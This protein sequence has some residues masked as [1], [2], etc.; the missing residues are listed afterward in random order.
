MFKKMAAAMIAAALYIFLLTQCITAQTTEFTYQ[1]TLQ[2]SS[3]PATGSFD[4]EFQLW[5]SLIGGTQLGATLTR[6]AVAVSAGAFSVKLDFGANFPGANR[7]LE[8]H[9]RSAGVGSFIPLLPRQAVSSSPYSVQ[10]LIAANATNATQLG[11]IA[12]NQYMTTTGG[13]TSYIQNTTTPQ[14]ANYNISGNGTVGGILSATSMNVTTGL[15][16]DSVNVNTIYMI[17]GVPAFFMSNGNTVAGN[18]AGLFSTG[19]SNSFYGQNAG[20]QNSIGGSNSFFGGGA[21]YLSGAGNENSYFGLQA[22]NNSQGN[23]NSFFGVN[24]G[25]ANLNGSGNTLI[26]HTAFTNGIVNNATA[27]GAN[28]FVSQSNSMVLGSI[29]GVNGATA[30]TNVGIGT[31][32]PASK[33]HVNGTIRVTNGAVYITNPNTVII[34][35]PNGACWGITVGNSGVLSTFPVSPCP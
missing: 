26:G 1:G 3:A 32:A 20:R 8:I 9:V 4:F 16:A 24:A 19:T 10:S 21:G 29:N 12:A 2:N 15:S 22:G 33:L 18:Q 34:T 7:F 28:S 17:G 23:R 31:T 13:N 27:I 30:D 11:G 14:T 35:S 5:D 6:S 25:L